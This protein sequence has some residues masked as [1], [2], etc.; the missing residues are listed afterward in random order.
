MTAVPVIDPLHTTYEDVEKTLQKIINA[1]CKNKML[2]PHDVVSTAHE[3]FMEAYD[4]YD[5]K[6]GSF[7]GWVYKKAVFKLKDLIRQYKA[8]ARL[9]TVYDFNFDEMSQASVSPDDFDFEEW[10]VTRKLSKQARKA[11]RIALYHPPEV[12][13]SIAT[14]EAT[15][16]DIPSILK[17]AVQEY[18]S[19]LGWAKSKIKRT[20]TEIRRAL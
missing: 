5:E 3:A 12:Q 6:K 13:L 2:D 1:F 7:N 19:D 20:F 9:K 17:Y 14:E 11:A 15:A 16:Y 10:C 8:K 4:T 18:L